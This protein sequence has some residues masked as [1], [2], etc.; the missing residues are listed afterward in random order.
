[1]GRCGDDAFA[2]EQF[3]VAL[4]Q[5]VDFVECRFQ[6]FAENIFAGIARNEFHPM[7]TQRVDS[8]DGLARSL[9]ECRDFDAGFVN[10]HARK[11]V[12]RFGVFV[13]LLFGCFQ[14]A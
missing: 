13:D 7:T 6:P 11:F 4:F 5:S 10:E 8:V 14:R 9:F 12:F 2:E 3:Q 1:M